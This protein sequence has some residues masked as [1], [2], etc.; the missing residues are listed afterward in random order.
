[1]YLPNVKFVTLPVSEIIGVVKKLG[2]SL[3]TPML[4]FLQSFNGQRARSDGPCEYTGQFE[5][6]S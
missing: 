1:M 4:P 2:Q 5:V 3:H 6:R